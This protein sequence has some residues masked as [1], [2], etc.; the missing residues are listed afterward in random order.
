L[1]NDEVRMTNVETVPPRCAKVISTSSF[2]IHPS[3]F[4]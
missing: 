3:A 1:P 4:A 2:F